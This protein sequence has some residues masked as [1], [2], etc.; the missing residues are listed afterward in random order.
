[1]REAI[2]DRRT[3]QAATQIVEMDR[4]D[5]S[6]LPSHSRRITFFVIALSYIFI[7][8]QVFALPC[9]PHL[10][11]G[12]QA[13]YLHNATRMLNGEMIYRDYDHFTLPG[14]DVVYAALFKCFGVRA[15]IPQ[16]VLVVLGAAL[17]WLTIFISRE[18]INGASA[19]LPGLLFI[20]LPFSSYLDATHHWFSLVAVM[21]AL[22]IL[23]RDR[24]PGR[25]ALAGALVAIAT[26]FTQ[27]MAL[28]IVGFAL[29]LLW[30]RVPTNETWTELL[31]K[32]AS[33]GAGFVVTITACLAY[34][35][36]AVGAEKI[37]QYTVIFV[38][39]YY[40]SDWFNNWRVYLT[41]RPQLHAW[42]SWFDGPAFILIHLI[43]PFVYIVFFVVYAGK[44]RKQP[45]AEFRRLVLINVAGL[46][47]FLT[48][49]SA[50]AYSRLYA[51][52]P[53]ALV[54]LVW[55]LQSTPAL[56]R[57]WLQLA[58]VTV[59]VMLIARPLMM[60]IRWKAYLDLPTGRTA[61]YDP[62]LYEKCKW[63]SERTH[64]FDYFFGDHLVAFTLELRNAGRVPFLRPTDYTRPEEVADA[65]QGIEKFHVRF[66]S[67]YIGLDREKDAAR[68]P[69]GN[70]LAPIRQYL[71]EHYHLAQTFSNGDQ[72]WERNA[73]SG[74]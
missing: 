39:K 2:Q 13:I 19:Y 26:F 7:Y 24:T 18:F 71:R 66:V 14:T 9:T 70:H 41:G 53:P 46:F 54:I 58:W 23:L 12:D 40:P 16:A 33:L 31:K 57:R 17:V 73:D 56:S 10:A 67:W 62:L 34:F 15:W 36:R 51:V 74:K 43:V 44:I 64:P 25:L 63:V 4:V 29:F 37:F 69:E 22:A 42:T 35:V 1:M 49:A 47:L 65:I 68:H 61:F 60:Q 6:P 8:L 32:E 30:E 72:I 20:A 27:S 48:I 50:P 28:L 38:A 11:T 5:C 21:G 3:R 45:S 59:F 55:F 52:S